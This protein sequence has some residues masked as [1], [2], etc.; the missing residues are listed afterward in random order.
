M[1]AC[2]QAAISS[3]ATYKLISYNTKVDK[4]AADGMSCPYGEGDKE[5]GRSAHFFFV[6]QFSLNKSR[7]TALR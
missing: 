6:N 1:A 7:F 3:V 2:L 5:D 4:V